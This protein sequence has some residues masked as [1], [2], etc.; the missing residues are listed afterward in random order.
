M[1]N[2]TCRGFTCGC[3]MYGANLTKYEKVSRC[4][5]HIH[6]IRRGFVNILCRINAVPRPKHLEMRVGGITIVICFS[7][8]RVR[9][10]TT[11]FDFF[12]K[13]RF[14]RGGLQSGEA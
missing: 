2:S 11:S 10:K 1:Q 9:G 3:K 4:N 6:R 8:S 5:K 13:V 7:K 12:K 14:C